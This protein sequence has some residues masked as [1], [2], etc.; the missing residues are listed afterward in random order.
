LAEFR[1][2]VPKK[3]SSGS[4]RRAHLAE[5]LESRR[6]LAG[7]TIITHGQESGVSPGWLAS[8]AEA[9]GVANGESSDPAAA[10]TKT[11]WYSM[12]LG[13]GP[14]VTSFAKSKG[15]DLGQSSTGEVVVTVDWSSLS[16]LFA[17]SST[18]IAAALLPDLLA[19][20]G[21]LSQ[22][23]AQLPV[24]LIGH[25]RGASV[26]SELARLMGEDG[27]WVDELTTLD[28]YPSS[29]AGDASVVVRANTIFA[30]N[31]YETSNFLIHGSSVGGAHNVGPLQLP[32][33]SNDHSDVHAWYDGTIDLAMTVEQD[34]P[35]ITIPDSWYSQNG[36][37]R[38]AVGFAWS[39][40][41]HRATRPGDGL[42]NQFA[43]GSI[44]RPSVAQNAGAQWPDI[45]DVALH[46]GG[47]S[48]VA[49]QPLSVDF[50]Y[51]DR[52]GKSDIAFYLDADQNPYDAGSL[53]IPIG[54]MSQAAGGNAVVAASLPLT[55]SAVPA[56]QYYL[57][58]KIND[59]SGADPG[60]TR[61]AYLASPVTFT[62]TAP[63]EI[64]LPAG[65]LHIVYAKRDGDGV[66]GDFWIDAPSPGQ[67]APTRQFLLTDAAAAAISV[68]GGSGDDSLIADFSGGDPFPATGGS[69]AGGGGADSLKV[70][71]TT[72]NDVLTLLDGSAQ[73]TG[74]TTSN[75]PIS[76]SGVPAVQFDDGG[77]GNDTFTI[78]GGDYTIDTIQSAGSPMALTLS[79]NATVRI[80]RNQHFG[81]LS[82]AGNSRLVL[83]GTADL[84][85]DNSSTPEA[86]VR[87]YLRNGYNMDATT[88]IGNWNGL[89]G[90]TSTD[91]IASHNGPNP[92]FHVSIGYVNGAYENDPIIGGSIPGQSGLPAVQL[93][94]RPALYGDLNLD[95]KVDDLDLQIF[96]GV[97]QYNKPNPKF[98]WLGG[99][100]NYDGKVD[101]TDLQ[102]FSGAGN[103]NGPA[104]APVAAGRANPTFS[105]RPIRWADGPRPK[106]RRWVET[107]DYRRVVAEATLE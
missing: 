14:S 1:I 56:G 107:D 82:I 101:D 94:I 103:Y 102:I 25:S 17:P 35:P 61:Y 3:S 41:A 64:V 7:L 74:G 72:G 2:V 51:E 36:V 80:G 99:D 57:M 91:A 59:G 100:L 28:P 105:I 26:M 95:G 60:R 68:L 46:G 19:P 27:I 20:A 71:G 87:Q 97:G 86:T 10:W 31:Y 83:V 85:L 44:A 104:Y 106:H 79:G 29:L 39:E 96:S 8:M 54:Q 70:I 50:K 65:G 22:A 15:P 76:L 21:G 34:S 67:G 30:D 53:G 58:A 98:G 52:D 42:S 88:G 33:G 73:F 55:T 47:S 62:T 90:I 6:L 16:S 40:L 38:D 92:N 49:G 75:A 63:A 5:A 45:A 78:S 12:T 18:Q 81:G 24:H 89:G 77:G 4:R 13:S 84:F 43:G 93:V 11:T 32:G 37:S 48:F 23:L 9:V 69:F 66:H